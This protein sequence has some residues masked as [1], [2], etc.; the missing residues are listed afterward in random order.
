MAPNVQALRQMYNVDPRR[1]ET[2]DLKGG[3]GAPQIRP[4]RPVADPR[5]AA[6]MNQGAVASA[7][8]DPRMQ[9]A[10]AP[11]KSAPK[12]TPTIVDPQRPLPAMGASASAAGAPQAAQFSQSA[13]DPRTPDMATI[14]A[15]AEQGLQGA[16]ARGQSAPTSAPD[17]GDPRRMDPL[18]EILRRQTGADPRA[19]S[20][21]QPQP[22]PTPGA[23]PR[24]QKALG[25]VDPRLMEYIMASQRSAPGAAAP[26]ATSAAS[27]VDPRLLFRR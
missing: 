2:M 9:G 16:A 11:G 10:A 19:A 12:S 3:A 8:A 26:P 24:F 1:L 15:A 21:V 23:D 6:W 27:G 14:L 22:Q 4:S 18:V 20:A 13:F 5:M 25:P 7:P 17:N